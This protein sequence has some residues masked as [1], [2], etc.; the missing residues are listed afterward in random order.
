MRTDQS[1]DRRGHQDTAG[2][3]SGETGLLDT[4]VVW[5]HNRQSAATMGLSMNIVGG[6]RCG[7]RRCTG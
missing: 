3:A 2:R 6:V 7:M 1:R 4:R 5:T